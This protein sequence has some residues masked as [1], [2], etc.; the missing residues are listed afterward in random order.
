M[1]YVEKRKQGRRRIFEKKLKENE[2]KKRIEENKSYSVALQN[3]KIFNSIYKGLNL[4]E[5]KMY[6]FVLSLLKKG[7]DID[8]TFIIRHKDIRE[9]FNHNFTSKEIYD[10]LDKVSSSLTLIG[11][12][13]NGKKRYIKIPIFKTIDTSENYDTTNVIFNEK[14]TE[15]AF[16]SFDKG[17]FLKYEL[18]SILNYK[19]LHTI[20][21]FENLLAKVREN[22]REEIVSIEYNIETLKEIL[23]CK[24]QATKDFIKQVIKKS[25]EEINKYNYNVLG[26]TIQYKYDK[27]KKTITFYIENIVYMLK[28]EKKSR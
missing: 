15:F 5:K 16:F 12:Y 20:E 1:D 8:T 10:I 6:R 27:T 11:T 14:Y 18:A 19:K 23:D 25:I 22:Q 4:Y 28:Q 24:K 7:D 9:L 17:H 13:K 2:K 26:G 3:E 21:I